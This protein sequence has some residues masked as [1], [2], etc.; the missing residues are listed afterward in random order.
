M[1]VGPKGATIKRIQQQTHTYIITPS[2]D[3]EPIFEVT[4]LSENVETA[5]NEI[6]MHIVSRTGNFLQLLNGE[7][8]VDKDNMTPASAAAILKEMASMLSA[9]NDFHMNGSADT[10]YDDLLC[11]DVGDACCEPLNVH[12]QQTTNAAICKPSS[13]S[14]QQNSSLLPYF[15]STNVDGRNFLS[16]AKV[17]S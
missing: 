10:A 3:K 12:Q 14:N 16:A 1:V 2:R 17:S 9:S 5:R 11:D 4:G 6:Q 8:V 15:D 13:M 7:N